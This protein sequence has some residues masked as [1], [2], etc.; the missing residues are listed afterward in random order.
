[1]TEAE[2]R[3]GSVS[4][5]QGG[6][7]GRYEL[8]EALGKGAMGVVYHAYDALLDRDVALKLMLPQI[9]DELDQKHR[10][11]REARAVAKLMHPNVVTL[12]DLGYHTDGSPYIAMELLRGEDLL[13][14]MRAGRTLLLP[15]KVSVVIQVL[16]GLAHAHAGGIVHRDIKPA[17]IFLLTDGTVKITDFGVARFTATAASG[18]GSVVGTVEYMSPE[19]V[20]GAQ[21]DGRSDVFSAAC[22]LCELLTG[23]R[24]FHADSLVAILY[25]IAHDPPQIDLPN[26]S[27]YDG[28]RP[29]LEKALARRPEDRYATAAELADD[30][31]GFLLGLGD[32]DALVAEAAAATDAADAPS[33]SQAATAARL[34][35]ANVVT[36]LSRVIKPV[37]AAPAPPPPA[38]PETPPIDP[39]EL[40]RLMRE[41]YVGGKSGHLH[42]TH[43]V[44]RR[45]LRFVAGHIVMGTS[46]V[47]GEHLGNI[48]VRFGLLSQAQLE[49][50]TEILLRD[51]KRLGTVLD[52]LGMVPRERMTEAVGLHVREILFNVMDQGGG[53]CGFEET[54]ADAILG[55]DLTVRIAPGE[56]VLEATRRIQDRQV[57]ERVVGSTQRVLVHSS[58][59]LLRTQKVPFTPTDGFLLSRVDGTLSAS[60]VFQLIPLD[61]E[62]VER[63]LFGLLC[64]GMLEYHSPA[65]ARAPGSGGLPR[66]FPAAL[67]PPAREP[68]TA[69][70][71]RPGTD[72]SHAGRDLQVEKVQVDRVLEELRAQIVD[73]YQ[74]LRM[75]D[76][77][78]VLGIGRGAGT[79][80]IKEAYFRL[81][82]PFHPDAHRGL[83][84]EDLA[85]QRHA[86]FIR[87]GEAY[88]T[89][90][91][92][93]TRA[94]YERQY[95]PRA[96]A[97]P[98]FT[99][100]AP[101]PPAP[102]AHAPSAPPFS[103]RVGAAP[104]AAPAPPR[105]EPPRV[106]PPRAA[107]PPSAPFPTSPLEKAAADIMAAEGHVRDARY[108]EAIKLLE[109]ILGHV[110]GAMETQ[111]RLLLGQ[112]YIKNPNWV[113][114][115]ADQLQI[116]IDT[117]PRNAE[118]H[119]LLGLVF[120]SNGLKQRA[121]AM[122][123]RAVELAPRHA[124]AQRELLEIE[125][126]LPP[127]APKRKLWG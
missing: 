16:D 5:R 87:L 46:D 71:P 121:A 88:D 42:F 20:Q 100:P 26:G 39:V 37:P 23:R 11:E 94:R 101:S 36:P 79:V 122:F 124:E 86:V 66:S 31:R 105:P 3:S 6:R 10:F 44:A 126:P 117:D 92:A 30:L 8:V 72:A 114:R 60:E 119:Y 81:A 55:P 43:G 107:A 73:M 62:D 25:K 49:L 63:S 75:K 58:Q 50:A 65:P 111:V 1:L 84:L 7:I 32:L 98:A 4:A 93:E 21:V 22:V 109:P 99:P 82:K 76:H 85:E 123:R 12:F 24:P 13:H 53:T 51:R 102:P 108:W 95:A 57:I 97:R 27:E 96:G 33:L 90:R 64:T 2:D 70:R 80:E 112:S 17:N 115:G 28:L 45:S 61:H 15:Q 48:L 18:S 125:P 41:I 77:F 118:A 83:P 78:E 74:G 68:A 89:L 127:S 67:P 35:T 40:F 9:A 52:E 113:K 38:R 54:G 120:K 110:R 106:E 19:Q 47:P 34:Q 56:V 116:V 14:T 91:H 59:P 69:G 103:T 29:L 104:P